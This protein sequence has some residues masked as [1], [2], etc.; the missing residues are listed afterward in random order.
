ME[1]DQSC[2]NRAEQDL[3]L[4]TNPMSHGIEIK[5]IMGKNPTSFPSGAWKGAKLLKKTY[6]SC[7]NSIA[8]LSAGGGQPSPAPSHPALL[9]DC[10]ALGHGVF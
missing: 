9:Q 4:A 3:S 6:P 5:K 7:S 10:P 8:R 2:V 1:Q